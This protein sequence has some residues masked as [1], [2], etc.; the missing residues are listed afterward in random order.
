MVHRIPNITFHVF[1]CAK[2][3]HWFFG[4]CQN[5]TSMHH[6]LHNDLHFWPRT[7]HANPAGTVTLQMFRYTNLR[8]FMNFA[9]RTLLKHNYC[10]TLMLLVRNWSEILGFNKNTC[11]SSKMARF[12]KI[13]FTESQI[14]RFMCS[15]VQNQHIGF[16]EFAENER[17]CIIFSI[18]IR[19]FYSTHV[20]LI[21]QAPLFYKCFGTQINVFSR[22]SRTTRFWNAT[23]QTL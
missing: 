11:I 14:S 20:M 22:I 9:L 3:T 10:N 8:F 13:W 4:I 6:I 5:R 18:A 16:S 21:P 19:T 17:Q 12:C 1:C 7:C 15:A 2:S 23:T